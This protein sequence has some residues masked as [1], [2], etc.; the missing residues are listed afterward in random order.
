MNKVLTDGRIVAQTHPDTGVVS[1]RTQQ[2]AT[3]QGLAGFYLS[4]PAEFAWRSGYS[5]PYPPYHGG[6][7]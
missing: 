1:G 5:N 4:S 7:T 6:R 3:D 2:L